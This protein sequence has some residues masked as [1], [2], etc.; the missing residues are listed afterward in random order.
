MT[1]DKHDSKIFF[2]EESTYGTEPID[3]G[4]PLTLEIIQDMIDIVKADNHNDG[5]PYKYGA[6]SKCPHEFI[7]KL[8]ELLHPVTIRCPDC[9]DPIGFAGSI[10]Y[11]RL[12]EMFDVE[13]EKFKSTFK[14][15]TPKPK[16]INT[17]YGIPIFVSDDLEEDE[18]AEHICYP[19]MGEDGDFECRLSG[20]Y[21]I[22]CG[23]CGIAMSFKEFMENDMKINGDKY[24][25][26]DVS[27]D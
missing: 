11:N 6:G 8:P 13:S 7:E 5:K 26:T 18:F 14:A 2:T 25:D 1:H 3:E 12:K 19:A 15:H 22:D 9:G 24:A 23:T 27:T 20:D 4:Q 16:R 17:L 21:P 10:L